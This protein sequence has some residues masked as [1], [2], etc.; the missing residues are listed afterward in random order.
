MTAGM[1]NAEPHTIHEIRT[2]ETPYAT[3]PALCPIRVLVSDATRIGAEMFKQV[4]G[5][6]RPDFQ[7]LFSSSRSDEIASAVT[8]EQP[9]VL[10][11]SVVLEDG[12]TAGLDVLETVVA[13]APTMRVIV[14]VDAHPEREVVIGAFRKGA[15]GIFSRLQSIAELQKCI[16]RV[17][18]GQVWVGNREIEFLIEA[19][20]KSLLLHMKNSKGE[21]I[22]TRREQEIVFHVAGGL[23]NAEISEKLGL[24]E[25]TIKNYLFRIFD[26]VGVS[27]R[28]ELILYGLSVKEAV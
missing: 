3:G 12:A 9:D 6:D 27:S 17:H 2:R 11:L 21:E 13:N 10:V 23:T 4:L 14:M 1:S 15:R 24:S 8:Q 28:V 5:R 25:H 16:V 20:M 19:L 7:L 18:G 22:L 26:K